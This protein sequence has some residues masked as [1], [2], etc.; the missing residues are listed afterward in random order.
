MSIKLHQCGKLELL[1]ISL[2]SKPL[3][4][5][6]FSAVS[7]HLWNWHHHKEHIRLFGDQRLRC[8]HNSGDDIPQGV[9]AINSIS[10][11]N[12]AFIPLFP[13]RILGEGYQD[14]LIGKVYFNLEPQSKGFPS[15]LLLPGAH[16]TDLVCPLFSTPPTY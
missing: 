14:E 4:G 8:L 2:K 11:L 1:T 10:L 7:I 5:K 3:F 12:M 13:I 9:L 6:I 15:L 16:Y